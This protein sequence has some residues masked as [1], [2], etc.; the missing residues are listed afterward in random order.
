MTLDMH[1]KRQD[2][3]AQPDG[4]FPA[5]T[6]VI[7]RVAEAMPGLW[8]VKVALWE[9]GQMQKLNGFDIK[10]P[11]DPGENPEDAELDD[12]VQRIY[13]CAHHG[14]EREGRRVHCKAL[15]YQRETKEDDLKETNPSTQIQFRVLSDSVTDEEEL[16]IDDTPGTA[17]ADVISSITPMVNA[18][19]TPMVARL[20]AQQRFVNAQAASIQK[21]Q[22]SLNIMLLNELSRG[23]DRQQ[24]TTR[25]IVG[26]RE[27]EMEARRLA[28]D[29]MSTGIRMQYDAINKMSVMQQEH[30]E[31]ELGRVRSEKRHAERMDMLKEFGPAF[32][33]FVGNIMENVTAA[34]ARGRQKARGEPQ[35]AGQ[36]PPRTDPP[37]PPPPY[38]PPTSQ[39]GPTPAPG[40]APFQ[41]AVHPVAACLRRFGELLAGATW[42]QIQTRFSVD[43]LSVLQKLC[44]VEADALVPGAFAQF[45]AVFGEQ[46]TELLGTLLTEEQGDLFMQ[47]LEFARGAAAQQ[48]A[49]HSAPPTPPAAPPPPVQPGHRP[50]VETTATDSASAPAPESTETPEAEETGPNGKEQRPRRK[51]RKTPARK[52]RKVKDKRK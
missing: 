42:S 36:H 4:G 50:V 39:P 27:S 8:R 25:S 35:T 24:K 33:P 11:P 44:C 19:I 21:Q 30:Y 10:P 40:Q 29:F 3:P 52:T 26:A 20:D 16:V 28:T 49:Q 46:H 2:L 9:N 34:F 17:A 7:E 22:E 43:Q 47:A 31:A 18:V 32:V 37:P 12:I 13:Q 15:F 6:P 45:F 5:D 48:A 14:S 41:A 38:N 1:D 23:Y 51:R